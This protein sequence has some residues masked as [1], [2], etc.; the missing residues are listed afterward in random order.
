MRLRIRQPDRVSEPGL[1]A[2]L[3]QAMPFKQRAYAA[4]RQQ[5][6]GFGGEGW[7]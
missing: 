4:N 1:L 5:A 3:R 7:R 2:V 6:G